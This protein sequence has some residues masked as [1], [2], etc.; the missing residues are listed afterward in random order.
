MLNL[1]K[2]CAR[3]DSIRRRRKMWRCL[4]TWRHFTL[5]AKRSKSRLKNQK[6]KRMTEI[7]RILDQLRRAYEG[8]AW[9]GPSVLEVVAGA[10]A[11]QAHARAFAN[12]HSNW[13]LVHHIAVCD[14]V[15][16]RN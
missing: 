11:G 10:T 1:I 8:E 13:E 2:R 7:E 6:G 3:A 16:R 14:N 4:R 9:H 5:N 12:A 15:C